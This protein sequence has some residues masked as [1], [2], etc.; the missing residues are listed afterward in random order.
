[1][2]CMPRESCSSANAKERYAGGTRRATTEQA[3][4]DGA[5]RPRQGGNLR[6][7]SPTLPS[8]QTGTHR[9]HA[10]RADT[11]LDHMKNIE[12]R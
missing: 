7:E 2:C 11:G 8:V 4:K 9:L 6:L 1:M 5:A 12:V 10:S 3:N